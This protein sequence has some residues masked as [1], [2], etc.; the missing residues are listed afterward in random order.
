M[1]SDT[2]ALIMPSLAYGRELNSLCLELIDG[3]GLE[4]LVYQPTR[5]GTILD[6]VLASH[7][8]M[9]TGVDVVPGISD[10]EVVLFDINLQSSIPPDKMS[11]HRWFGQ[12]M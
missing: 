3:Y 5:Q 4:Q 11:N 2:G 1:W 9:I 10:H 12:P 6:I 8:E 7:P